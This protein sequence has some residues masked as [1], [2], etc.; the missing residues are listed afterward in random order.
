M[1]ITVKDTQITVM[2]E[3]DEKNI[4]RSLFKDKDVEASIRNVVKQIKQY[5]CE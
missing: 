2:F 5:W 3:H 4:G 1:L